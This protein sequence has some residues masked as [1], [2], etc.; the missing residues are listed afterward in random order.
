MIRFN[1]KLYLKKLLEDATKRND[2]FAPYFIKVI[3]DMLKDHDN[4]CS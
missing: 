3:N 4:N 2:V 1:K